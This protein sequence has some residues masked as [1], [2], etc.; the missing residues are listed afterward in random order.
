MKS[1]HNALKDGM[2]SVQCTAG[3]RIRQIMKICFL[4][5]IAQFKNIEGHQDQITNF[6]RPHNYH[7]SIRACLVDQ[8]NKQTITS[9]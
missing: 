5:P 3:F 4:V 9:R 7:W 6:L 1:D 8:Q 2:Y